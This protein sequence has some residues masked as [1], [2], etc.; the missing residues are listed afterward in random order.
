MRVLKIRQTLNRRGL[1]LLEHGTHWLVTNEG[2]AKGLIEH[3]FDDLEAV[4]KWVDALPNRLTAEEGDVFDGEFAEFVKHNQ[5][6]HGVCLSEKNP[7]KKRVIWE[8]TGKTNFTI[9]ESGHYSTPEH[10][11]GKFYNKGSQVGRPFF[12]LHAQIIKG[13]PKWKRIIKMFWTKGCGK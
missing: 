7:W 3:K 12:F 11:E 1:L 2:T 13:W 4:E 8:D 5:C 6:E 9:Q 10:P